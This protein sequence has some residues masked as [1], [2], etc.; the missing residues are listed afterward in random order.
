MRC[1]GALVCSRDICR[2]VTSPKLSAQMH[3]C[4][5]W[6]PAPFSHQ[7]LTIY[8]RKYS[9]QTSLENCYRTAAKVTQLCSAC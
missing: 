6:K 7:I 9:E 1:A 4:T 5:D 8:N 3:W 2:Q